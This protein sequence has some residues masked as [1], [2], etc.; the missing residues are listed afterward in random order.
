[1]CIALPTGKVQ[2][3]LHSMT[4]NGGSLLMNLLT[5]FLWTKVEAGKSITQSECSTVCVKWTSDSKCIMCGPDEMN[6]RLWKA[7]ASEKLGVRTSQEKAAKD[8]SQ[9]LKEKFQQHP[10]I[11]RVAGHQHLP[12]S[13]YSQI[14]EQCIIQ[15]FIKERGF[16]VQNIDLDNMELLHSCYL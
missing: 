9:E 4:L 5:S 7:N 6:I 8:Y 14:Q 16:R 1:M 3:V 10:Q 15:K 12:K 13:I 11:K 2:C